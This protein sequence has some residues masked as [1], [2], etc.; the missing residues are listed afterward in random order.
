MARLG[1]M[2]D[3]GYN[4]CSRTGYTK[5]LLLEAKPFICT[6]AIG[7]CRILYLKRILDGWLST[8]QTDGMPCYLASK[9]EGAA[10]S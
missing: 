8:V 3:D 2:G 7:L 10:D 1:L 6:E 9:I 4:R 5:V